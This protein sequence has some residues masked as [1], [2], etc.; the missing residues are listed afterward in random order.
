ML[1]DIIAEE[2]ADASV[3]RVVLSTSLKYQ[4]DGRSTRTQSSRIGLE[5]RVDEN[6]AL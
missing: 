4:G 1:V 6:A 2:Q 3:L 5:K